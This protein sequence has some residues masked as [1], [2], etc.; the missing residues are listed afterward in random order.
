MDYTKYELDRLKKK[1]PKEHAEILQN[2]KALRKQR[3][4]EK[5]KSWNKDNPEKAK[6]CVQNAQYKKK[7]GITLNEYEQMFQQQLGLCA[8]CHKPETKLSIKGN[9]SL[10]A[11]DH[12]HTTGKIR[13]LL[14]RNCNL[15]LGHAKDSEDI[16]LNAVAYLR[17]QHEHFR[18]L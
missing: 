17:K 18:D 16:L 13:G 3:G 12:C 6:R 9:Q 7:Y 4:E 1:A 11:V 14:C 5:R 2:R 10:L 8:I 15:L